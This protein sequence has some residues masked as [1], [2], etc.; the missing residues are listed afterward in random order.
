MIEMLQ[1]SQ[2]FD[3]IKLVKQDSIMIPKLHVKHSQYV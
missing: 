1:Y 3:T 2:L